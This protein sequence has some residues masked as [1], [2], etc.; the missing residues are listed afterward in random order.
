MTMAMTVGEVVT[1]SAVL[2]A[3]GGIIWQIRHLAGAFSDHVKDDA[4]NFGK[5]GDVLA[6]NGQRLASIEGK[7][8]VMF[9][10]GDNG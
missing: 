4:A 3:G 6:H 8:D 10:H 7:L 1:V 5:I 9:S 2:L